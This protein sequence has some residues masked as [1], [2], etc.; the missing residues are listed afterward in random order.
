MMQAHPD[1]AAA[2]SGDLATA[3]ALVMRHGWLA[4]SYQILNPGIKLWFPQPG[5][6]SSKEAANK[7]ANKIR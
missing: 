2:P 5:T 1:F 7:A 4:T 3:R 6:L